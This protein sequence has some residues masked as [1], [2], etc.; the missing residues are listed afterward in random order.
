MKL[1]QYLEILNEMVKD[2]PEILE[3]DV[4]YS[5]DDEGNNFDFVNYSPT[6]GEFKEEEFGR[7]YY[8]FNSQAEINKNAI[9]LN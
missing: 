4:I 3:Y 2:N 1:K 6:V 9:C 8:T 5:S 7:G